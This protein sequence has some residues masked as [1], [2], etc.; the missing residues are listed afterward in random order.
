MFDAICFRDGATPEGGIDLGLLAEALIFYGKVH[1]I[2]NHAAY[3]ALLSAIGPHQV[4]EL[5][6]GGY[7][8]IHV[9]PDQ[10]GVIT[11]DGGTSK[12]RH[13]FGFIKKADLDPLADAKCA[14]IA[15]AGDT[16][17]NEAAEF[18]RRLHVTGEQKLNLDQIRAEIR[19]SATFESAVVRWLKVIAPQALPDPI[20]VQTWELGGHVQ[21]ATNVDFEAVSNALALKV[22]KPGYNDSTNCG[23]AQTR[24]NVRFLDFRMRFLSP[25]ARLGPL[26]SK[27]MRP[28]PSC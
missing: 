8:A 20:H 25:G 6:R 28:S 23:R 9:S 13:D 1:F 7:L 26:S 10:V 5:M 21:I 15:L 17:K 12:E 3:D 18:S 14:F 4:L 11:T 22:G 2:S 16:A 27:D 24:A 19:N